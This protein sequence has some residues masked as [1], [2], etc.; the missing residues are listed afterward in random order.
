VLKPKYWD[1]RKE[2]HR[3]MS[4]NHV[5]RYDLANLM[6][7]K[8]GHWLSAPTWNND[9][10]WFEDFPEPQTREEELKLLELCKTAQDNPEYWRLR[11]AEVKSYARIWAKGYRNL[12]KRIDWWK[13]KYNEV[14][15]WSFARLS[16]W[17]RC[18]IIQ[19][20]RVKGLHLGFW[21]G[22]KK[23]KEGW[24]KLGVKV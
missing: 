13:G 15:R 24:A 5:N 11:Y 10:M 6:G 16:F 19:P 14:W 7:F 21:P 1:F 23:F 2:L 22:S 17:F 20:I 18:R 9:T 12:D 8:W 3:A 4:M